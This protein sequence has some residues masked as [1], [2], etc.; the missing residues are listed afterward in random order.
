MQDSRVG[1]LPPP[2]PQ[3]GPRTPSR[4]QYRDIVFAEIDGYRPLLLDLTVPAARSAP[5]PLLIWIHGGAWRRGWPRVSESWLAVADPV[6]AALA[7]GYA[8]ATIQYRLSAEA[9]YPAQLDDVREAVT[10]LHALAPE[11]GLDA[12]RFGTWGESAGGHLA[13]MLGLNRE[14]ARPGSRVQAVVAWYAPS[15]LATLRHGP[16]TPETLLLGPGQAQDPDAVRRASPLAHVSR[17]APPVLLVHGAADRFVPCEQSRRLAAALT[18]RGATAE[19]VV[20]PGADHCFEG[21]DL[22]EPVR[23]S[24]DFFDRML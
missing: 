10:V 2:S 18:E 21:A 12:G 16:R 3:S 7:R 14:G 1:T 15:D 24:L 11:A 13:A 20:I 5:A 17:S 19:L 23:L 9:P 6:E 22:R 4:V 8:V